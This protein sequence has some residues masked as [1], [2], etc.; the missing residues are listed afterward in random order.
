MFTYTLEEQTLV[1][2]RYQKLFDT[3][4]ARRGR[5]YH[6]QPTYKK[7]KNKSILVNSYILSNLPR[8]KNKKSISKIV[9]Y[10]IGRRRRRMKWWKPTTFADEG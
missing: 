7:K 3:Q 1:L 8:N 10:F 4:V 2:V 5:Q 6:S 9:Y